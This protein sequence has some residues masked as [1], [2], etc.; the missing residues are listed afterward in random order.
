MVAYGPA[1]TRPKSATRS[2]LSAPPDSAPAPVGV[3]TASPRRPATAS[4]V[5]GDPGARGNDT[6]ILYP[7]SLLFGTLGACTGHIIEIWR[8]LTYGEPTYLR[9]P[10]RVISIRRAQ[11]EDDGTLGQL[12]AATWT[13]DVSP[14]P[15][16]PVGTEFFNE[17]TRPDDVLVAVIDGNVIGYAKLGRSSALPS[18]Q[19][20][21]DVNG[22]TVDPSRQRLGAGRALI[23]A[24]VEEARKRGARKLSLRVL[25]GNTSA[26]RLYEAC[27]FVVEGLLRDEFL[28]GGRYVDDVFMARY[29]VSGQ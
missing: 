15:A 26:R 28:L 3:A 12:D 25:G 1:S 10:V 14:T 19:H 17:R 9:H 11:L 20:V 24:A 8:H 18:H 22:L 21:L 16:P 2:P 23:E 7:Q 13:D 4:A 6:W 29:L 5:G 27:G